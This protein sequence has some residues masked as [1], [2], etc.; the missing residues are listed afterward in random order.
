MA[1]TKDARR[2]VIELKTIAK[3]RER[4]SIPSTATP[5]IPNNSLYVNEKPEDS[6]RALNHQM[7]G[8]VR[9]TQRHDI[10]FR[11]L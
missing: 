11:R 4:G 5:N 6:R 1:A 7:H 9:P 10:P 8:D 2:G 3:E